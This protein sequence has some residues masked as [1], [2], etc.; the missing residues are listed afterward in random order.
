MKISDIA[1]RLGE[2]GMSPV[3]IAEVLDLDVEQVLALPIQRNITEMQE[4]DIPT[5]A[6]HIS[7]RVYEE[8]MDILNNGSPP[9]KLSII[10]LI[11]SFMMRGAQLQTPHE[12]EEVKNRFRSLIEQTALTDDDDDD[13]SSHV[14]QEIEEDEPTSLYGTSD[15][16]E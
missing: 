6:G 12:M 2:N 7:W 15:D 8:V 16:P 5:L 3:K 1:I 11:L 13:E 4:L 10:R 14:W 9:Q